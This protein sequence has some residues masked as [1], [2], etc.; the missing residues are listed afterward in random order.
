MRIYSTSDVTFD[1]TVFVK[2]YRVSI[3]D[4]I[5]R[6]FVSGR[7]K[8]ISWGDVLHQSTIVLRGERDVIERL[9]EKMILA[10][11]SGTSFRITCEEF[12]T[13]FGPEFTYVGASGVNSFTQFQVLSATDEPYT[14]DHGPMN[15]KTEWSV[16]IGC[17]AKITSKLTYQSEISFP[18][19]L[20]ITGVSRSSGSAARVHNQYLSQTSNGFGN[21]QKTATVT[22]YGTRSIVA[23]A[24]AYLLLNALISSFSLDT[25]P[26]VFL[27]DTGITVADVYLLSLD[28]LGPIS[29]GSDEYGFSATFAS[30]GY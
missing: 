25:S 26:N 15:L 24:K 16:T 11:A 20:R 8:P 12:E 17:S 1:E 23:K 21:L 30:K 13:I 14:T 7:Y 18:S 10:M 22:F 27:F 2:E 29:N 4:N 19:G 28:D 9:R 3:I 5:E 6:K